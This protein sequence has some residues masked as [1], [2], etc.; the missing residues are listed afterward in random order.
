MV[1]VETN[2]Y[3]YEIYNFPNEQYPTVMVWKKTKTV[4]EKDALK[5]VF[6]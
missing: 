3:R 1:S 2:K 4:F 5:K 6:L